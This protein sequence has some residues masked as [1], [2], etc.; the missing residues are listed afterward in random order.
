MNCCGSECRT[1]FCPLCGAEMSAKHPLD[2]LLQHCVQRTSAIRKRISLIQKRS[3]ENGVS[4]NHRAY[5]LRRVKHA[6]AL[7]EKWER[8]IAELMAVIAAQEEKK[9]S[10]P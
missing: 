1:P 4:D 10:L 8:W 6:A 9:P 5:F 3:E 2:G 7:L